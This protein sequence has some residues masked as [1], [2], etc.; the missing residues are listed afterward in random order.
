MTTPIHPSASTPVHQPADD[1]PIAGAPARSGLSPWA[2]VHLPKAPRLAHRWAADADAAT[3]EAE[4]GGRRDDGRA[5][6]P[7]SALRPF[8]PATADW[9][10]S[11]RLLRARRQRARAFWARA[12]ALMPRWGR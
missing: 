3:P 9:A 6:P 8:P 2:V 5:L 7:P 10:T 11:R 4:G 12:R 1:L